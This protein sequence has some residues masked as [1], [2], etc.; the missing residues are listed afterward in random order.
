MTFTTAIETLNVLI[1]RVATIRDR[2]EFIQLYLL[3]LPLLGQS[4]RFGFSGPP[5]SL[6]LF[7]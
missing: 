6:A 1:R 2:S 5:L 4:R 7:L 3:A